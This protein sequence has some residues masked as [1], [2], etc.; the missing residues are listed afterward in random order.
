M[1]WNVLG[2]RMEWNLGCV[3]K[4]AWIQSFSN[5]T[6]SAELK[7]YFRCG[8]FPRFRVFNRAKLGQKSDLNS[9]AA[10]TRSESLICFRCVMIFGFG[11]STG[12]W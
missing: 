1:E 9:L 4:L 6:N 5:L 10:P 11:G 2:F 3:G 7:E 12:G 8:L